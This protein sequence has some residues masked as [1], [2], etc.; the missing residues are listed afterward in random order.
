[1]HT[2]IL[3]EVHIFVNQIA[4]VHISQLSLN[5]LNSQN[6]KLLVLV[7]VDARVLLPSLALA[8]RFTATSTGYSSLFEEVA[9]Q[10]AQKKQLQEHTCRNR[11]R[12][13]FQLAF[14]RGPQCTICIVLHSSLNSMTEF[15]YTCFC[16]VSWITW[17]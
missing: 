17:F 10:V 8:F 3:E 4:A 2:L 13:V 5:F 15:H 9:F 6:Y 14:R 11:W 7:T 16:Q 12:L 1:M